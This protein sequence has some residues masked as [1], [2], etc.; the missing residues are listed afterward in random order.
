MGK[1]R[2]CNAIFK[3]V[4]M[5]NNRQYMCYLCIC[6]ILL[7]FVQETR[8]T[9]FKIFFLDNGTRVVIVTVTIV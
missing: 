3:T 9:H 7:V 4:K 2:K 5:T 6:S 1:I 8:V